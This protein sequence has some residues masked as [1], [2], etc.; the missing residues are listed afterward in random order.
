M[1]NLLALDV[2][3]DTFFWVDDANRIRLTVDTDKA[4]DVL[5]AQ[6]V[7]LDGDGEESVTGDGMEN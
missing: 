3:N 1:N 4:S 7:G 6:I 5:A 2:H